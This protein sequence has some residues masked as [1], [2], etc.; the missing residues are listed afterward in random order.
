MRYIGNKTNLLDNIDLFIEEKVDYQE[1]MIFCDFFSGT[2]SVARF[3]KNKY[4]IIS[5]DILY[6][7]YIL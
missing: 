2:A 6:F 7:S 5:N 4:Q 1:N 3:F